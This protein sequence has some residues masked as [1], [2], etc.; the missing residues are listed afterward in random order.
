MGVYCPDRP[1]KEAVSQSICSASYASVPS[2][3]GQQANQVVSWVEGIFD[4][5]ARSR[6]ASEACNAMQK[7]QGA[8]NSFF[9]YFYHPLQQDASSFSSS[10]FL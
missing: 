2:A 6:E 8:T 7:E 5:L 9:G 1:W 10:L 3:G 4:D